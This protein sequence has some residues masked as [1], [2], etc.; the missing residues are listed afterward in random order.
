M[1][2]HYL[3]GGFL[4]H[5]ISV[6]RLLKKLTLIYSLNVA[7]WICTVVLLHTE[8]FYEANP[9]MRG[10]IDNLPLGFFA[11]CILP[12]VVIT[13]LFYAIRL[14]DMRERRIADSFISFAL[15][16]YLVIDLDHT[17]NFM[18]LFFQNSP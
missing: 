1:F 17:V 5:S 12:A 7:D 4:E 9:L 2:K 15:V 8:I 10:I 18:L 3:R 14:L 16:F 13:A 6:D 11:K